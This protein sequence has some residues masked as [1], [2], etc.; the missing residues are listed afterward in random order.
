MQLYIIGTGV[1][2]GDISVNAFEKIKSGATVVLRTE[3]T[4]SVN[5]L[6][7]SGVNYITLDYLYEKSK[8]FD[9][10]TKNLVSA[11]KELLKQNDVCYLVDGAVSEDSAS[12]VLIKKIKNVTVYEGVSKV[13]YALSSLKISGESYTA[14]SAYS[15]AET[16]KINLPLAV[17]DL[18]NVLLASEWKLKLFSLVGEEVKV[19]LYARNQA[20]SMP[21]YEID[22]LDDYDYSTVLVVEKSDLTNKER[23]DYDDLIE[24]VKRLR[25]DGGC[26]WDKKQTKSTICRSLIEECYELV[27]A[28]N[29]DSDEKICEE[30]GDVLLQ[31]AFY[32]NFLEEELSYDKSDVLTGICSKLI[33][34]HSHVFGNDK[35]TNAEE[36]LA[37]WNKNKQVE[38]G[39]E[40]ST[41]YLD[42]VPKN[43]PASLR[44]EK[45]IKRASYCNYPVA[46]KETLISEAKSVLDKFYD[47]KLNNEDLKRLLFYVIALVKAQGESPEDLI[48]AATFD[49]INEFSQVE[50]KVKSD[51]L[52]MKNL[53]AK[54]VEKYRNEI[55]KS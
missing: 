51:G 2:S 12:A 46:D 29:K 19:R 34:R 43:F 23:F 15:L 40:S 32:I 42:D 47:S 36:A 21:L 41:S 11:V 18:D 38:K 14:V 3:K 49:F 30:T 16:T 52:D 54:E 28:V 50:N 31:T 9:T 26:P 53:S 13:G 1:N 25:G 17:Y 10:L 44:A 45:V 55:K 6:K 7:E 35:A 39:Y 27:D 33:M 20:F 4:N 5:F 48:A 37:V 24:I 22:T 8:N